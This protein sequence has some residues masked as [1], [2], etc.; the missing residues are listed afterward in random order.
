MSTITPDHPISAINRLSK[1]HVEGLK[2][3]RI[4][5]IKDLLYHFPAR[6][7]SI[8]ELSNSDNFIDGQQV[9]LLGEIIKNEAKK[10]WTSKVPASQGTLKTI[11]GKRVSMTWLHQPYIAKMYPAGTLVKVS[12]TLKASDKG[13]SL[14]N[15][16]IEKTEAMAIDTHDSLFG[17]EGESFGGTLYPETRGVSSQYLS[18]LIKKVISMRIHEQIPDPI[19]AHVRTKLNL[20]PLAAALVWIHLP[21]KKEHAERA[22]KRFAFEQIFLIQIHNFYQKKHYESNKS[23]VV[24]YNKKAIQAFTKKLPFTLTKTQQSIVDGLLTNI[25]SDTPMSRLLE[26][27]VGSG[28]TIIAAILSLAVFSARTPS[29]PLQVAYMAPTEVLANQ[30]FDTFTKLLADIPMI[31]IGLMTS[32]GCK[33]F[34]S[35]T[36]YLKNN[37][38]QVS[39]TQINKWSQDGTLGILIGT[40]SLIGKKFTPKDLALVIIDEQH[41][42]GINQRMK[43]VHTKNAVP[44]F[45]SMSATPI[46]RTL[47]LT[48]YGDLDLS[49]LDEV[50]PGRKPV[51]TKLIRNQEER[52][53]CYEHIKAKLK[54]GR[55]AYVICPRINAADEG[56]E[57]KLQTKSV[58]SETAMLQK[59]VGPKYVV[60]GLHGKLSKKQT[61]ETME[62]FNEGKIHILIAT[63]VIEVGVNVPN[64]TTILIEGADRFGLAQLHQ[65]RGR[66]M[67]GSHEPYCFLGFSSTSQKTQDRLGVFLKAKNGFELAEHDLSLRGIG[68]LA[69]GKQWGV[70]DLAMEALKN[71]RLVEYAREEARGIIDDDM[72]LKKHPVLKDLCITNDALVHLE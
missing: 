58:E 70:S 36:S 67:R 8:S 39:A 17:E 42:F 61:E 46:P 51:V 47:A 55:Q 7:V 43:L 49:V 13:A 10:T 38:T 30:L 24:N 56:D 5:S 2:K 11:D 59:V 19:P 12:G 68:E 71:P 15:P 35:K 9:S 53:A 14:F 37:V 34:P 33:K 72:E 21:E 25:S 23:I 52:D 45:L 3:L 65:L 18:T 63:S 32:S 40:H 26:G 54:E 27:D 1:Q 4:N 6:Y 66:V 28:K 50:P 48:L 22:R 16:A 44:H 64:A 31:S 62:A 41:R 20:P 60:V 57:R 29:R 69:G